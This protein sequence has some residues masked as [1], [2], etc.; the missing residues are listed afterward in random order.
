MIRIARYMISNRPMIT[1]D[2]GDG[3][4]DY[5]SV[6]ETQGYDSGISGADPARRLIDLIKRG[7]LAEEFIL[8]QISWVKK[9]R[10]ECLL[11]TNELTPLLPHRPNKI[12]CM[13]R[14]WAA[15]AREGGHEPPSK[16]IFFAKTDNCAIGPN[17][18]IVLPDGLGRVDHEGELGVVI[19][20]ITKQVSADNVGEHILGYCIVNDVTAREFQRELAGNKLPWFAAKSID[21]F[22]PIG[23]WISLRTGFEPIEK[24]KI[25]VSV[26]DELKQSGVMEEMIWDVPAVIEA[27]SAHITLMPGDIIAAG[28][29]PGIGPLKPGDVVS[30]EIEDLGTLSNPVQ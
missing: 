21:T 18:P 4:I 20:K 14:N 12:I 13:A 29:P 22:A 2:A 8:E 17:E 16:P 15:H 23:P 25:N 19:S 5:G 11:D 6:L 10:F 30:V 24:K 9:N 26:N 1:V 28:T 27:I 7:M 3:F